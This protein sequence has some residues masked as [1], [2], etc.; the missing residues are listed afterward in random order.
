[1]AIPGETHNFCTCATFAQPTSFPPT[2]YSPPYLLCRKRRIEM[3]HPKAGQRV[4]HR[5]GYRCWR[6]DRGH[7]P[8]PL[9]PEWVGRRWHLQRLQDELRDLV[10]LRESIVQ[11]APRQWLALRAVDDVFGQGLP[12]TLGDAADDLP[13]NQAWV[14]DTATVV[15]PNITQ[16]GDLARLPAHLHDHGMCAKG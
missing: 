15:D 12:E 16:D 8:D 10:G 2:L 14:D 6:R 7:R 4:Q 5:I 13:F 1:M 11:Q 9:R 3:A